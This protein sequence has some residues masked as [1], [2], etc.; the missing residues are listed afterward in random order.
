MTAALLFGAEE[1]AAADLERHAAQ[2]ASGIERLGI[3]EGDVVALMLR[4]S[5]AY[6]EAMLACRMLGAYYGPINGHF[7]ADG[8]GFIRGDSGAKALA[9]HAE[10]LPQIEGGL[11]PGLPIVAVE[12]G[13]SAW[14]DAHEPWRGAARTPRGNMPY[15]SGT[16]GRPK[17]VRP[18]KATDQERALALAL[19]RTLLGLEPGMRGFVSAPLYHSAPNLYAVQTVMNGALLVL[20]PRFDA[21]ATLALIERHRLTNLYLVPTMFV[22]MLRLPAETRRRYD[23]STVRFS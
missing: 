5:P 4:N 13:W 23:R 17:G 16:T 7:K 18:V 1:I 19:Y 9:V 8:A 3:G 14:R 12:P 15:T 20:E 6:L 21:E 11:P 2:A 10:F 22:R